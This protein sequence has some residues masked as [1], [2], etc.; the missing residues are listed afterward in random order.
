VWGLEPVGG[1]VR[2]VYR[3][4]NM[5]QILC[6]HVCKWKNGICSRNRRRGDKEQWRGEFKYDIFD[7]I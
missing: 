6:T 5:V 4:E 3:R 1:V 7:T 2:K